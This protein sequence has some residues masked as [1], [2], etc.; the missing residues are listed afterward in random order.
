MLLILMNNYAKP[1]LPQPNL[2]CQK[3]P[4]ANLGSCPDP[5]FRVMNGS[6]KFGGVKVR[7][8]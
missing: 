7:L 6:G 8:Y 5:R 2:S 3:T 4:L 1:I